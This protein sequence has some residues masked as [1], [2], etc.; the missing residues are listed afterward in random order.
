MSGYDYTCPAC[1]QATMREVKRV[2]TE[3]QWKIFTIPVD[4]VTY[5]CPKCGAERD[6]QEAK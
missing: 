2:R 1:K 3:S 5:K 6:E 4:I